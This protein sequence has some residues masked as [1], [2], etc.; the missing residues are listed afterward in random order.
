MCIS[1][2]WHRLMINKMEEL[3]QYKWLPLLTFNV[4]IIILMQ[5]VQMT[6][7]KDYLFLT[8]KQ[9]KR[10]FEVDFNVLF[11]LIFWETVFQDPAILFWHK[12]IK[13]IRKVSSKA[14]SIFT[15]DLKVLRWLV[16]ISYPF[17]FL[18]SSLYFSRHLW[19]Q[20]YITSLGVPFWKKINYFRFLKKLSYIKLLPLNE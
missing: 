16:K 19:H 3:V 13:K 20:P 9:P 15:E 18:Y 1:L 14:L 2:H 4:K 17:R 7:N 8:N 5:M 12:T 10:H 6:P 11:S